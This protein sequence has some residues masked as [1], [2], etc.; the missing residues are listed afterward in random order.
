VV[1][2]AGEGVR[3]LNL[4]AEGWGVKRLKGL[5]RLREVERS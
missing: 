5:K 3:R 2:V 1:E 4:S